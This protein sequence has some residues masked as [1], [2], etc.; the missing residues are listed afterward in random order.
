MK[1]RIYADTS[2]FSAYYDSRHPDRK[3]LTE[4]FWQGIDAFICSA[5]E[6]TVSEIKDTKDASLRATMQ[7]LLTRFQIHPVTDEMQ[8]L[9]NSYVQAGAFTRV[10]LDDA[11]HV[12]VATVT[13]QDILISWNFRHLV[14]RRRRAI[15]NS[16]NISM[17]M[18]TIDI[19]SPPEV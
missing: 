17:G 4:E 19:L 11:I 5:S 12:A 14:N 13:R 1:L 18:P 2:V 16:V 7:K 8:R 6:L 9:A 10:M 3:T 15:V